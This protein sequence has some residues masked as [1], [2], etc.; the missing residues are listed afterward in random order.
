M[1]GG[2]FLCPSVCASYLFILFCVY[3]CC[4]FFFSTNTLSLGV[5]LLFVLLRWFSIHFFLLLLCSVVYL[6]VCVQER[7]KERERFDL[8]FLCMSECCI[9][10]EKCFEPFCCVFSPLILSLPCIW[11]VSISIWTWT[12]TETKRPRRLSAINI[13]EK[14]LRLNQIALKL[15]LF[16]FRSYTLCHWLLLLTVFFSCEFVHFASNFLNCIKLWELTCVTFSP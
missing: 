8:F 3:S 15:M 5:R 4:S 1:H 13:S 7:Q 2:N 10:K 14:I 11:F 12:L 9:K 6:S 16:L